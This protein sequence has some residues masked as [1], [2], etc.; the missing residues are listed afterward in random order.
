MISFLRFLAE[1]R[2]ELLT[3]TGEHLTLVLVATSLATAIG[4]PLGVVLTRRARLSGP[5]LGLASLVQTLPSLAIFGFLIPLPFI[6]GIGARSATVALVLYALL[7]ILRNTYAGIRGVD[8]AVR[9]AA[10]GL[11]MTDIELMRIVEIPLALPTILT[12]V[13][14]AAVTS[15]GTA[16]IAAAIGAGG[17]GTYVFRGLATVD[18]HLIL[19]GAIPAAGMALLL[20]SLLERVER[21]RRPGAAAAATV[22][23]AVV[24][25]GLLGLA[26]PR[27][28]DPIVVGSKNFTEQ[29]VLGEV[30]SAFLESRGFAVERRMNLGGTTIC[31]EA[32]LAGRLDLYA[33]YSGTALLDILKAPPGDPSQTLARV[34]EGYARLG[35]RLGPQLGFSDSFA[36]VVRRDF[37]RERGLR[38]ISD[39]ARVAPTVR[40]GLFGEFLERADGLHALLRAYGLELAQTP[41]EMDLGLLYQSLGAGQVDL[42]VGNSTDGMIHR[43]DLLVLEDDRHFFPPYEAVAVTSARSIANH[44]GLLGALSGLAGAI[45]EASMQEMN[46]A[47]DG[48][49][50]SPASVA[51]EFLEMRGLVPKS[52]P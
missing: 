22:A 37:A 20:D 1:R 49:H 47:V 3:L 42:V 50:R 31:H 8:P 19:A 48:Q 15:V 18:T 40:L 45:D 6:G 5:V 27:A 52:A 9:E 2:G 41:R 28:Q 29:V 10:T 38:R 7:P 34:E 23:G 44:P 33:E 30:L 25:L 11:G 36:L 32:L 24:L 43:M 14:I 17:L 35:L 12:G 39:L 16:T 21:S 4:F 13:R 26:R 46:D 51:R